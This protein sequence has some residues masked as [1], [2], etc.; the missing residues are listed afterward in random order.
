MKFAQQRV[1]PVVALLAA[2]V[3]LVFAS[4]PA[5]ARAAQ[6]VDTYEVTLTNLTGGQAFS[7]PVL[8]TH[9]GGVAIFE[10]G[11]A[12]SD[13]IRQIAENGNNMVLL[14]KLSNT[15]GVFEVVEGAAPLVPASDPGGTGLVSTASYKITA[16]RGDRFLSLATMLICTNDGFTGGD[17]LKLPRGM[18]EAV[19]YYADGYDAGTEINTEE[20]ADLVPP[21]Q[22]LIGETGEDPGTGMSNPALFEGGVIRHHPGIQG[23]GDLLPCLH[24]WSDPVLKIEIRRVS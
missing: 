11:D 16:A 19:T 9:R 12:A 7:P 10:V 3:G 4:L 17:R 1:V 6:P 22:I 2:V 15:E 21:C 13:G 20:F 24:N 18:N 8:V 14:D 23:T 5:S